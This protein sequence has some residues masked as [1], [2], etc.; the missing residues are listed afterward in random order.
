MFRLWPVLAQALPSQY[1]KNYRAIPETRPAK[2]NN[3]VS[4]NERCTFSEIRRFKF[5]IP[6]V[7]GHYT[8]TQNMDM[9]NFEN[10]RL[11]ACILII[12]VKGQEFGLHRMRWFLLDKTFKVCNFCR[13]I[14]INHKYRI[15]VKKWDVALTD[16]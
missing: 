14:N 6:Y 8:I 12:W 15:F 1:R 10:Y 5:Q 9:R 3:Q 7:T 11:A 4:C 13:F 16:N 2:E